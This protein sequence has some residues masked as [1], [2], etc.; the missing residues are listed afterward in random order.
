[1]FFSRLTFVA[2][3]ASLLLVREAS[4]AGLGKL[5][6]NWQAPPGCPAYSDVESWLQAVIPPDA[7]QRIAELHVKVAISEQAGG[8]FRASVQVT[9]D[10]APGE[11]APSELRV[12]EGPACEEVARSAIVV[13]SVAMS[14]ALKA[15]VAEPVATR[16]EP[17]PVMEPAR[18]VPAAATPLA[19]QP[20][21]EPP[22]D[23]HAAESPPP[24]QRLFTIASG[25]GSGFG[26]Q[27]GVRV[28][29]SAL[30][31]LGRQGMAWGP[32]L[33]AL[34]AV[35]IRRDDDVAKLHF[36]AAGADLCAAPQLSPSLHALLCA[37]GEAGFAWSRGSAGEASSDSGPVAALALAPGL[38][39]G[40]RVRFSMQADFELRVVRPRFET[41]D[42][43]VLADLPV[44]AASGLIGLSLA[45]P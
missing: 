31:A 19:V 26:K 22:H 29:A 11:A 28:D 39:I 40:R 16:P 17:P 12:V 36:V 3:L 38:S 6:M 27:P 45:L 30:F 41:A 7:R 37:R 15:A 18:P 8:G 20:R 42:G 13:V 14:D 4:A 23:S 1:V 24:T 25:V 34:P 32:H 5:D 43:K 9:R 44:L 21:S 10:A 35:T 33:H 2:L